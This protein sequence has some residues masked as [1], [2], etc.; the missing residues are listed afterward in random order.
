[1]KKILATTLISFFTLNVLAQSEAPRKLSDLP[2]QTNRT[3]F[4]VSL[5]GKAIAN[6][7]LLQSKVSGP[8]VLRLC[9]AN[10]EYAAGAQRISYR[11]GNEEILNTDGAM[12]LTTT[13]KEKQFAFCHE[14]EFSNAEEL[15]GKEIKIVARGGG[16]DYYL[17]TFPKNK[18]H[19][20]WPLLIQAGAAAGQ[21]E[22][23][24][25]AVEVFNPEM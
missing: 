18:S 23:T 5:S 24:Y 8:Y 1:M 9:V 2:K 11:I 14:K 4:M 17:Q 20:T 7:L 12:E 3:D 15:N 21:I 10:S 19:L 25:I 16:R 22:E 6:K 13:T